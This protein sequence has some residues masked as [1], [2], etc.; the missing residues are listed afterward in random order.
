MQHSYESVKFKNLEKVEWNYL[1][2]LFVVLNSHRKLKKQRSKLI[3]LLKL[4]FLTSGV[5]NIHDISRWIKNWIEG[6]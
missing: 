2:W 3:F 6:C 1:Q 4:L 5:Y